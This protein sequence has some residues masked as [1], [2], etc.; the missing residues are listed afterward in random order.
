MVETPL[1]T[2]REAQRNL[3][4]ATSRK[5]IV[6]NPTARNALGQ[7]TGYAL[8]PGENAVPFAQPDSWVRRRAGVPQLA[9]LGD[10]LP[11]R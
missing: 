8:L 6:T 10:A 4:L 7:P 3:D 5:W 2:E 11:G 9:R 1:R